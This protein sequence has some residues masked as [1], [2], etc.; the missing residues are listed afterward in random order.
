MADPTPATELRKSTFL[1]ILA[2]ALC[3]ALC[4]PWAASLARPVAL[5][6]GPNDLDYVRGFRGAWERDGHTTFRWTLPSATIT[7]PLRVAGDGAHIR[8]RARRHFIEPA[9]VTLRAEGLVAHRFEIRARSETPYRIE[10]AALP[11][12]QGRQPFSIDIQA[13]STNPR[14]LGIA[15]DWI[16]ISPGPAGFGL[17]S[18]TIIRA[19]LL[20]AMAYLCVLIAGAGPATAALF[21]LGALLATSLG[22]YWD[23][24]ATERILREGLG[25]WIL[26]GLGTTGFIRLRQARTALELSGGAAGA[27]LVMLILGALALRLLILLHPLFFY[28]DVQVHALFS[29]E[30]GKHGLAAFL[31]EFTANQYRFSL[32]LQFENGHWYAFPY[33]PAFYLLTWPLVSLLHI[34]AEIAVSVVAALINS[35]EIVVVFALARRLGQSQRTAL[36]AAATVAVLPLFLIRLSLAY[37]PA[38]VGQFVDAAVLVYLVSQIDHVHRPRVIVTLGVLISIALLTYTQALVNFAGVLGVFWLW[39]I[40][41]ERSRD[42]WRRHIGLA[43]AGLLGALLALAVFYGRYVPTFL[44][45]RNGVPMA[46]EQIL[47][48]KL[49]HQAKQYGTD[50]EAPDD[51]YA[52]LDVDLARGIRKAGSRFWLFYGPFAPLLLCGWGLLL[53]R[54][55]GPLR[56]LLACWGGTYLLLNLGSGGLPGPNLLRYNKDLEVIA[57]VVCVALAELLA[58]LWNTRL[59]PTRQSATTTGSLVRAVAVMLALAFVVYGLG[60]AHGAFVERFVLIGL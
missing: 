18:A 54:L 21:A 28:P 17:S 38:L 51:P 26:A 3:A 9:Q 39:Q 57:P 33:P 32:G 34:R 2:L 49:Q 25:A 53:R 50:Q 10:T 14:P 43:A 13:P 7:L 6:F 48:E 36:V 15:L 41:Q 35:L 59:R 24:L 1:P 11:R 46:E 55:R 44:D 37:F 47:T 20:V 42:S 16:E 27:A 29:H 56:R 12:L 31:S 60:R 23:A 45:M 8:L 58:W 40:A 22:V 52:G 19:V 4:V 30:L 5:S